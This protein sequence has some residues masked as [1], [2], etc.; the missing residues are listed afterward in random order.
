MHLLR[1]PIREVFLGA[2]LRQLQPAHLDV[3]LLER[4]GDVDAVLDA[5]AIIVGADNNLSSSQFD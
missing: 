5:G 1:R 4:L 3:R 2:E